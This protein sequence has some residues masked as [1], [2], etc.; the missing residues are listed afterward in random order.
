ME[1]NT[2]VIKYDARSAYSKIGR[3]YLVF[4]LVTLLVQELAIATIGEGMSDNMQALVWSVAM[5]FM[6][7]IILELYAMNKKFHVAAFEKKKMSLGAFGKVFLMCYA[8]TIVSNL[9]GITFIS[10]L[11][12]AMGGELTN[13]VDAHLVEQDFAAFFLTAVAGAPIFEELFFRKFIVDRTTHY[14]SFVSAMVSGLM[15]GLFHGNLFQFPY[16]FALGVCFAMVYIRT[17]NI[18]YPILLHAAINF[19]GSIVP[20]FLLQTDN[21]I[22][23]IVYLGIYVVA[24]IIGIILW[25]FYG[26]QLFTTQPAEEPIPKEK[27]FRTAVL[28]SGMITYGMFWI[29][30]IILAVLASLV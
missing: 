30:I 29:F 16:A 24:L 22:V 18:L 6:G 14:G 20:Y 28:N 2:Q 13:P 8:I 23:A 17:G 19:T 26:K 10:L 9:L 27:G 11:E 4:T 15:F 5:Y 21:E 25:I 1:E 3:I 12:V 7:S